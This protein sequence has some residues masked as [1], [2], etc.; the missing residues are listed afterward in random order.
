MEVPRFGHSQDFSV[1][2]GDSSSQKT[3]YTLGTIF[4]GSFLFTFF[5]A[6]L[7][8][9][10]IFICQGPKRAGYLAGFQMKHPWG[11][12]KYRTPTVVRSIFVFSCIVVI[13]GTVL[14]T[15][16]VGLSDLKSANDASKDIISVSTFGTDHVGLFLLHLRNNECTKRI[17]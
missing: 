10:T 17:M 7:V 4:I 13:V 11:K 14:L 16:S 2:F 9:L 8:L 15:T 3:D 1:L 6:W 5:I 12:E